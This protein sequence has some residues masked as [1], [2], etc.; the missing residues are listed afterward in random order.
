MKTM[1]SC[2]TRWTA[3]RLMSSSLS[4]F[5]DSSSVRIGTASFSSISRFSD[6]W[7]PCIILSKRRMISFIGNWL[8]PSIGLA[9]PLRSGTST[10]MRR[11][12]RW[13]MRSSLRNASRLCWMFDGPTRQSSS[14]SSTCELTF[15]LIASNAFVFA[16]VMPTSIRSRMIWSTSLPTK[17]TSV[18][19]VASTLR[20]GARASF[21]SRRATSVLP[22]ATAVGPIISCDNSLA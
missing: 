13:P 1:P 12:S 10:S 2:S 22:T 14:F 21:A 18:N 17:P 16:I 6:F 4:I 15:S 5:S 8:L 9:P 3:L 19:L 20:N 11:S 7:R